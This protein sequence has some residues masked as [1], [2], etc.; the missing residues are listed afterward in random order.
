MRRPRQACHVWA[1]IAGGDCP[2]SRVILNRLGQSNPVSAVWVDPI[3]EVVRPGAGVGL[4]DRAPAEGPGWAP[5]SV[6]V[7]SEERGPG[8]EHW[9]G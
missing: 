6:L 7:N 2:P 9:I 3:A 5:L 1:G 8:D 4:C